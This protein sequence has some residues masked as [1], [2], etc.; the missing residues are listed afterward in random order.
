MRRLALTQRLVGLD[1]LDE[2]AQDEV[3]LDRH[4]L[5]A[6]QRSVVVEHRQALGDRYRL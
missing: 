3:E 4:R 5:L 6:P 2:S 1:H